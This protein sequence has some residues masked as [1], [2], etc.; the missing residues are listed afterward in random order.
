MVGRERA[1]TI[2]REDLGGR[3]Q[4][5]VRCPRCRRILAVEW[6]SEAL[7]DARLE[8]ET[9]LA[10]CDR[11]FRHPDEAKDAGDGYVYVTVDAHGR[12]WAGPSQYD[13]CEDLE[14]VVTG[15]ASCGCCHVSLVRCGWCGTP[16]ATSHPA[17]DTVD[18]Y[19]ECGYCIHCDRIV[20]VAVARREGADVRVFV[21]RVASPEERADERW[22][23]WHERADQEMHDVGAWST[24]L[25]SI[26]ERD[27]AL[28]DLP[29]D[30]IEFVARQPRMTWEHWLEAFGRDLPPTVR[31]PPR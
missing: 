29:E 13:Y 25:A 6:A 9:R 14:V 20:G 5:G 1:E 10:R 8:G 18:E 21:D 17:L 30:A 16:V 19:L 24:T 7:A 12:L 23:L 2:Y 11:C 22:Q 4:A 26:P 15:V 3:W 28:M 31:K 27:L